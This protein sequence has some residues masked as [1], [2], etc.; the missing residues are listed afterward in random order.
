MVIISHIVP[1]GDKVCWSGC[2]LIC[3]AHL[4][5][6][7]WHSHQVQRVAVLATEPEQFGIDR[8]CSP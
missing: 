6:M 3:R 5:L 8:R 2:I 7:R 1:I 4:N